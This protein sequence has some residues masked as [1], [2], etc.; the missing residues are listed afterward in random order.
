MISISCPTQCGN[1]CRYMTL[2]HPLFGKSDHI[3]VHILSAWWQTDPRLYGYTDIT[4][5]QHWRPHNCVLS[6]LLLF[7]LNCVATHTIIKFADNMTVICLITG[8]QSPG[9]NLH[10]NISKTKELIVD[11][12]KW[13]GEGHSPYIGESAASGV[14]SHQWGPDLYSPPW[15]HHKDRDDSS[16]SSGGWGRST[17]TQRYSSHITRIV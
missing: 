10:L 12:G 1:T 16:T 14:G 8:G 7:V 3:S 15:H 11:F 2:A 17:W 6:L 13:Q 4:T 5:S 9:V